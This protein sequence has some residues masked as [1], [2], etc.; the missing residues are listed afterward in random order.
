MCVVQTVS[1]KVLRRFSKARNLKV[2]TSKVLN[3]FFPTLKLIADQLPKADL[4]IL[5][6]VKFIPLSLLVGCLD[7]QTKSIVYLVYEATSI[8]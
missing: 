4:C 3:I 8:D 1:E 6:M 7:V 2:F 5:V